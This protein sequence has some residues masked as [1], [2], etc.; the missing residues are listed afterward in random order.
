MKPNPLRRD[1]AS[2]NFETGPQ[3]CPGSVLGLSFWIL[4]S[5]SSEARRSLD[6]DNLT[7]RGVHATPPT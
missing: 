7:M 4:R 6:G 5:T 3:C 2:F 1:T